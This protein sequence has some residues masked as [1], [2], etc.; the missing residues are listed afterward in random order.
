M[1]RFSGLAVLQF[2]GFAVYTCTILMVSL[3]MQYVGYP[4][5]SYVCDMRIIQSI[6]IINEV[7]TWTVT[8]QNLIV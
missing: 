5:K 2:C 7:Y 6:L 1:Y 8:N 4:Y 3:K